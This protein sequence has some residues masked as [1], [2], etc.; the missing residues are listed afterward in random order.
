MDLL[1]DPGSELQ[2][3]LTSA[4]SRMGYGKKQNGCEPSKPVE[5]ELHSQG[6]DACRSWSMGW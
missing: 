1:M 5:P 4:T 2:D 3:A 6:P